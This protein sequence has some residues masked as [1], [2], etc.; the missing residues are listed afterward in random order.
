AHLL[1]A[2]AIIGALVWV[3]LDLRRLAASDGNRPARLTA[4]AAATL[5]VLAVQLL[6]GAWVA[7]LNAGQVAASW[8]DMNGRFL[9][10]GV[11]WS[12]GPGHA[13]VND[14]YLVHFIHRW[15]AW[16]TVAALVLFARRVRPL[17]RRA[18]LAIHSAFGLQIL[19]GIATV[20]SGVALWLAAL[21]QAVGALLVAATVW[22]AHVHG[23]GAAP[24]PSRSS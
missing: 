4:F 3:A 23:F 14:P 13:L 21:H 17:D 6:Y 16:M 12:R 2:L 7:G 15:W 5:A 10:D 24:K 9:P 19:L 20:L 18:S 22:G 11:D 1:L 8:P